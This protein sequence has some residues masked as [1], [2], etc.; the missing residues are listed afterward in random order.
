MIPFVLEKGAG[1]PWRCMFVQYGCAELKVVTIATRSCQAPGFS[2]SPVVPPMATVCSTP[3]SYG[4]LLACLLSF[5]AHMLTPFCPTSGPPA[6]ASL[7]THCP[8][9]AQDPHHAAA[10][11]APWCSPLHSR[12]ESGCLARIGS[13]CAHQPLLSAQPAERRKVLGN[14][15]IT[16]YFDGSSQ[17]Q[18][19]LAGRHPLR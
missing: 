4:S 7:Q 13:S 9:E 17:M 14:E 1:W 11:G 18:M 10:W 5:K 19:L 3:G 16:A 2:C 6:E 12:P 15:A 8:R